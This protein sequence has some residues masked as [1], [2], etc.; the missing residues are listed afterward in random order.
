MPASPATPRPPPDGSGGIVVYADRPGWYRCYDP[1]GWGEVE[2][3]W[4][5]IG[6]GSSLA[7]GALAAGAPAL[8]AAEIGATHD[9]FSRLPLVALTLGGEAAWPDLDAGP[10]PT[11]E[12]VPWAGVPIGAPSSKRKA[13]P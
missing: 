8:I 1:S 3:P 11:A 12:T 13:R 7:R 4:T 5:A 9:A 10:W 6:S 2:A